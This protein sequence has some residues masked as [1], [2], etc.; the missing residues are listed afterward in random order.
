[1]GALLLLG[2]CRDVDVAMAIVSVTSA[3]VIGRAGQKASMVYS[4]SMDKDC[5][6]ADIIKKIGD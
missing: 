6:T 3:Y 5:D 2:L 1:M 4:A